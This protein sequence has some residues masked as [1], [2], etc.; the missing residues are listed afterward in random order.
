MDSNI[1]IFENNINCRHLP[2]QE[3]FVNGKRRLFVKCDD[4]NI[5]LFKKLEYLVRHYAN[6]FAYIDRFVRAM[7][8]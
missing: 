3:C 4:K 1:Y 5:L 7:N 2:V 6:T 8:Y